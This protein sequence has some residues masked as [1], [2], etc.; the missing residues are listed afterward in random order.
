MLHL[1]HISLVAKQQTFEELGFRVTPTGV[2]ANHARIFLD[3]TYLEVT[4]P[5]QRQVG[6]R[7][8]GWFLRPAD[9]TEAAD[10]LRAAGLAAEGPSPYR[11]EDGSWLDVSIPAA[12]TALPVL[13]KRT[14]EP[15]DCWPPPQI[16]DHPN[17]ATTL[18]AIHLQMQDPAPLLHLFEALGVPSIGSDT[19]ELAGKERVVVQPS[20]GGTDGIVAAIVKGAGASQLT[21]ETRPLSS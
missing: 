13:T 18:A 17:G 15:E 11:G 8:G 9:P 4:P 12:T 16:H 6:I 20:A 14:D 2:T 21:L 19:F 10:T 7:A 1:D 3:R 5:D